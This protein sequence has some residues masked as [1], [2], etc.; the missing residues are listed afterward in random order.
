MI[1]HRKSQIECSYICDLPSVHSNLFIW[2]KDGV[3]QIALLGQ[4]ILFK[5]LL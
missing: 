4:Q 2:A 5:A 3:A 1:S